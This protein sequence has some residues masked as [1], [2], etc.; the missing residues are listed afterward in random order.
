MTAAAQPLIDVAQPALD[1]GMAAIRGNLD[2]QVKKGTLTAA[3]ADEV[4]LVVAG[5]TVR[6]P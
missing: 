3:H 6:L 4:R 2:R 1:R 5:R